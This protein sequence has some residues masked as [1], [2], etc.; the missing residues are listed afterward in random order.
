LFVGS[1][2]VF[3]SNFSRKSEIWGAG[4]AQGCG[5]ETNKNKNLNEA[6]MHASICKIGTIIH[7]YRI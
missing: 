4:A 7:S 2:E 3:G 6:L 1:G 5:K